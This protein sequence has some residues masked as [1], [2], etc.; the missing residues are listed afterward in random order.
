MHVSA[1]PC[2]PRVDKRG[3]NIES[4]LRRVATAVTSSPLLPLIALSHWAVSDETP[5]HAPGATPRAVQPSEA[6]KMVLV[7]MLQLLKLVSESKFGVC[8]VS[9]ATPKHDLSS[10]SRH[11]ASR[12]S[13]GEIMG[14]AR[15]NGVWNQFRVCAS[16]GSTDPRDRMGWR[17]GSDANDRMENLGSPLGCAR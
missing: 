15:R 4:R 12:C 14:E 8:M 9:L 6:S 2:K 11:V 13:V 17:A 7:V 5:A 1:A 10:H 16:T 3:G